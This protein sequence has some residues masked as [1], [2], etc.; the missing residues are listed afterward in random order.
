MVKVV[1]VRGDSIKLGQ[2]LKMADMVASGGEAKLR[3]QGGEVLVNGVVDTRRGHKLAAGDV[4]E[5]DGIRR[6][7]SYG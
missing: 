2:F 4:V 6:Q 1:R 5:C 3:V 7:V